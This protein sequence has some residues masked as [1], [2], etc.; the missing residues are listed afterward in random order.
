MEKENSDIQT[1]ENTQTGALLIVVGRLRR[2]R[3]LLRLTSFWNE[4]QWASVVRQA[5]DSQA[6]VLLLPQRRLA[7]IPDFESVNAIRYEQVHT[8]LRAVFSERRH[9]APDCAVVMYSSFAEGGQTDS[10]VKRSFQILLTVHNAGGKALVVYESG[11]AS[12]SD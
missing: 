2:S 6:P 10:F 4:E 8:A 3:E 12:E 11:E 1:A 5:G 7:V 9:H